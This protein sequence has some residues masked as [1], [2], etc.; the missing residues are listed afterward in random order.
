MEN[1]RIAI[2]H[3]LHQELHG[4]FLNAVLDVKHEE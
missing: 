4:G 3:V 2:L 1:R